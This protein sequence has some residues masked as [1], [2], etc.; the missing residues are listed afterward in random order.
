[1][2]FDESVT[3]ELIAEMI[4]DAFTGLIIFTYPHSDNEFYLIIFSFWLT[5]M[6]TF[7]LTSGLLSKHNKEY[8]WLFILLGI[9]YIVAGFSIMNVSQESSGL[10]NYFIGFVLIIYS[11]SNGALIIKRKL[12][13]LRNLKKIVKPKLL[14]S[15][16]LSGIK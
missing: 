15:N 3:R 2:H 1:M 8:L 11:V 14:K 5:I 10:I 6:G 12:N 4:V 7:M 16:F 9:S 13:I